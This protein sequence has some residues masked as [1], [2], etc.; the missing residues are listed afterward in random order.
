MKSESDTRFRLGSKLIILFLLIS[1]IPLTIT[2]FIQ[3]YLAR[4]RI[5]QDTMNHLYLMSTLKE[6]QLR[7]WVEDGKRS[8]RE[9]ARR[10]LIRE[11][12]KIL[13]LT[14]PLDP[15]HQ[16]LKTKIREEHFNPTLEE[17][18][19][20]LELFILDAENGKILVSSEKKHEGMYREREPYFLEGKNST[21]VQNAYYSMLLEQPAMTIA[22]PVKSPDVDVAAVL[23]ARVDLHE[24]KE[25]MMQG[26]ELSETE[27]TYLVNRF[28]FFVTESRFEPDYAH[29]KGH[30][31]RGGAVSPSKNK[32]RRS[33]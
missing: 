14:D 17:E 21:F 25:I 26:T 15:Q 6:T 4:Q 19:G 29:K 16:K 13:T 8:I 18:R 2:G 3:F 28:N 10:P 33:V 31:Y 7:R 32:R 9:L 24:M 23:A 22:T 30:L 20:S 5:K 1:T 27:E 11:Y 12:T